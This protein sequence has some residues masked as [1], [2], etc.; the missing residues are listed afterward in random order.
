MPKDRDEVNL[1]S[2]SYIEISCSRRNASRAARVLACLAMLGGCSVSMP[3]ASLIPNP[4]DD[5]TGS[6]AKPQL[7]GWL[8]GEDWQSAKTAFSQALDEKN[9]AATTWDNPKS[10]AK[11]TFVAVGQ[12][13]PGVSGLCRAF[14]ADIDREKADKSL[15]GTAC[16]GKSGEW[17]VTEVKPSKQS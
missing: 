4:H 9:A 10:G 16:A 12:A 3:M 1:K 13:Y 6:V 15:E 7:A 2:R 5:E 17:Q 8:D 14:H 11:G